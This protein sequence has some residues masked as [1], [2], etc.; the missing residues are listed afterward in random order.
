M[1][2]VITWPI[3]RAGWTCSPAPSIRISVVTDQLHKDAR[4]E[5]RLSSFSIFYRNGN[6]ILLFGIADGSDQNAAVGQLLLPSLRENGYPDRF[7]TSLI[8]A[9]GAIAVIIPPSIPLI[10]YGVVAQ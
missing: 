3:T 5:R 1:F 9:S 8:A 10:I 4:P 7:P 6:E 2:S